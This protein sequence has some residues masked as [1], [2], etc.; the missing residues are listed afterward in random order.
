MSEKFDKLFISYFPSLTDYICKNNNDITTN[1]IQR[2]CFANIFNVFD[3]PMVVT[4][5]NLDNT[6]D[7][8]NYCNKNDENLYYCIHI[9]RKD[10]FFLLIYK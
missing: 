1:P 10:N 6:G 5:D 8:E 3:C 7:I 4:L 2:K 9:F